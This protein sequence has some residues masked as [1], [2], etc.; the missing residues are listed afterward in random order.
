MD[1]TR[2]K[3]LLVF[4]DTV[5]SNQDQ[6]AMRS[7]VDELLEDI[8]PICSSLLHWLKLCEMKSSSALAVSTDEAHLLVDIQA[9]ILIVAE[10]LMST[11]GTKSSFRES[12]ATTNPCIR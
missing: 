6:Q 7:V 11:K 8:V 9:K 1:F 5:L 4:L 3:L 12:I 10:M 2:G